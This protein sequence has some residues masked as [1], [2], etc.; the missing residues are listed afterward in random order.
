MTNELTRLH[1]EDLLDMLPGTPGAEV[2]ARTHTNRKEADRLCKQLYGKTFQEQRNA[3]R[4][5]NSKSLS[6]TK[7]YCPD[8]IGIDIR[9]TRLRDSATVSFN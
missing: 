1:L 7:F 2:L 8:A 6:S 5:K 4:E 3:I 9:A